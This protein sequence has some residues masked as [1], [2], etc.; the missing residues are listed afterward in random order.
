MDHLL[1]KQI[2]SNSAFVICFAILLS[3]YCTVTARLFNRA[4]QTRAIE[5]NTDSSSPKCIVIDA[6]HGG[7]DGGT[8]GINGV[9]EKD[10]NLSVSNVLGDMLK[11]CGY[12]VVQTRKEDKLLYDKNSDYHGRKKM[13]D[14]KGRLQIA[15]DTDPDVFIGIHMNSFPEQKYSGLSV[16][17]SQNDPRSKLAAEI[18]SLD[19]KNT[20][21]PKNT[22]EIKAANSSIYILNRITCPAV[23]VECG[24]L[25]NAEE[26]E[27]LSTYAYRRELSLSICSSIIS[28]LE[29]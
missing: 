15:I 22:R 8:V 4:E 29:K 24:F 1:K 9:L 5:V 28:F 23:L 18:I 26:C 27:K 7:E 14:L 25:S 10:L 20:L 2:I 17:Y 21:Q 6:G 3:A 12:E 19:V 13:L 16:Y 11:F